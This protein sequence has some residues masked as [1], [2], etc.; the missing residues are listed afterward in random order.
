MDG[1]AATEKIRAL[2]DPKK[3]GIPIVALTANAFQEDRSR[4][5]ELGMDEYLAKPYEIPAVMA[6]LNRF[7]G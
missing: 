6:V 1:Y 7:L 5:L 4:S 3:A 2:S